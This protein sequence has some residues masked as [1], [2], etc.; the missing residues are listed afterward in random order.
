MNK[1]VKTVSNGN[2]ISEFLHTLNGILK[3]TDRELE[4]MATLIYL[5]IN[6]EKEPNS[7]KNVANT[8]NRRY[9]IDNLGI[10]KDN[11]SRYIKSF[12]QKGILLVGPA[13]D[14][15]RVNPA[16][17]PIIINDRVQI[18]VILRINNDEK[19]NP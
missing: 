10:T 13:E 2:L 8:K 6:Y 9:I 3:L 14:E 16:L 12:K 7:N 5:D 11:L 17:I 4:L 19:P 18:T 1:L 15:L